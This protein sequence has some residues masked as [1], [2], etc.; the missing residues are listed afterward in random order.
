[1]DQ[2]TGLT[3]VEGDPIQ[4]TVTAILQDEPVLG[5]GSGRTAP[6]AIAQPLQVRIERQGGRDGRV[7]HVSFTAADP[8]GGTCTATV[9]VCVPHDQGD[10]VPA[11]HSA[12]DGHETHDPA[13]LPGSTT[14]FTG[15]ARCVDQGPL[16][17][18]LVNP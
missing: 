3:D 8:S 11:E 17:D 1:M 9:A 13:D 14:A 16:Y 7:Y 18:S 2:V 6:D 12:D 10:G 15:R 4:V 5:S